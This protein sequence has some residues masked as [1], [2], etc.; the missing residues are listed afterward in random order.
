MSRVYSTCFDNV[1]IS[2]L[3][4]VF[5]LKAGAA[6]GIEIHQIDLSAGGV[7]AP[8]EIR[9]RLKVIPATVT[10]GTG[11]SSPTVNPVDDGDT[12]ASVSTVHAND[13]TTQATSSG[14]IKVLEAHQW[15]V[16]MPWQHLPPPED[17]IIIQAG[18]AFVLD[19]PT[20]PGS[21]TNVSGTIKWRELP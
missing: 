9:L 18:E 3:Q 2:A 8:A 19:F 11:G 20:A 15:N 13:V 12:K 1:S 14:T 4:D 16:L 17:R 7:T 10:Q 21:A 5:S 6:N